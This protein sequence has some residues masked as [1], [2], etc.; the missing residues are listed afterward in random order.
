LGSWA[1]A[2][3]GSAQTTAALSNTKKEAEAKGYI[4]VESHDEIVN[5]AK[6]EGRLNVVVSLSHI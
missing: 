6:K 3:N 5:R 2:L 1:F 4:L